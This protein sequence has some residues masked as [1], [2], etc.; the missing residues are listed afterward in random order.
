[1]NCGVLR[2]SLDRLMYRCVRNTRAI[3]ASQ[4]A[5]RQLG[6]QDRPLPRAIA[7]AARNANGR[8][9]R[10]MQESGDSL[11]LRRPNIRRFPWHGK[12]ARRRYVDG[13]VREPEFAGLEGSAA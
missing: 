7:S 6:P 9:V 1:M 4:I 11:R 12:F 10:C 3:H 13:R 8:W 5:R 2:K